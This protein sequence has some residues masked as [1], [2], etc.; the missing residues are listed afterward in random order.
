MAAHTLGNPF[1]LAAVRDFC[2]RHGLWLVED[3]CDALGSVYTF[4]GEKKLTGTIGDIGTSSFY[5]PHHM[6]M[7]EGGAV[8][9]DNPLLNR[10][11][12]SFRD[13]GRDC[14]CAPG[15]D[16]LCGHRYDGQYGALP[17]GYDHK[18]VY[19]HFGYN[20]K[21][22]DMQAAIGCA[23]LKKFP[24]FVE[25]RI[26]NF[27]RL[28]EGLSD[29]ADKL[30]LPEACPDS[31]PSWFGFLIT[32]REGV[33][34]NAVVRYLEAHGVQTR[35]LFAG[36]LTKHPCFDQM[37]ESRT[38]Y[39]VIGDVPNTERIMRDTFW[40]GVYPGMTDEMLDDMIQTIKAAIES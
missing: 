6:T 14:A 26:H 40:I 11:V 10:I 7:G 19:S 38:G 37:R 33:D 4:H 30:I 32:C 34:R 22:T 17:Q 21:A 5:P 9:T 1:D 2:D 28:K 24:S 31:V 8:Y 16:N 13:W 12:R 15:Q 3:N 29:A 25:R 20:L 35:M 27:N 36:N 39:R 18:Y 23:Q